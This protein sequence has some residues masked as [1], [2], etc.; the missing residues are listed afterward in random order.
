MDENT[1]DI[2]PVVAKRTVKEMYENFKDVKYIDP[3]YIVFIAF[4]MFSAGVYGV[5]GV[6]LL[7]FGITAYYQYQSIVDEGK[8]ETLQEE[9]DGKDATRTSSEDDEFEEIKPKDEGK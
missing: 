7:N 3:M 5:L 8:F 4:G 6:L 9:Q 2:I 1:K